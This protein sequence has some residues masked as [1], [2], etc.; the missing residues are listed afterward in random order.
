MKISLIALSLAIFSIWVTTA[1]IEYYTHA[2]TIT[3]ETGVL[4]IPEFKPKATDTNTE[5]AVTDRFAAKIELQPS[6]LGQIGM[7]DYYDVSNFA[8]TV[9]KP[10]ELCPSG[11]C[12]FELDGG[13]MS[14]A[15]TPG[16]RT[17]AGKL[18]IDTDG[19]SKIMNVFADWETVEE[20]VGEGGETV[21]YIEGTF[22]IGRDEF[23]PS[24]NTKSMEQ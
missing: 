5:Q 15:Y 23:N 11:N 1:Q 9:G 2:Q 20:K 3:N 21:Q 12:E 18:K 17:L 19:S 24:F 8:F 10:S 22:G 13:E 7:E 16:E 14:A 4:P 6:K